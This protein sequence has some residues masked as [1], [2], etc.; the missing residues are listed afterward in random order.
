MFPRA[1][2]RNIEM[3]ITYFWI[4]KLFLLLDKIMLMNCS[5]CK[6]SERNLQIFSKSFLIR[7]YSNAFL[8]FEFTECKNF[9]NFF[10]QCIPYIIE[11]FAKFARK[12]KVYSYD[13]GCLK[14]LIHHTSNGNQHLSNIIYGRSSSTH[15]GFRRDGEVNSHGND[16][17][18]MR[19][20]S[21]S[22]SCN[23][24]KFINFR[25]L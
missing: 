12:K 18:D 1:L 20:S 23:L 7:K 25:D 17:F 5:T 13:K 6:F 2:N 19:F 4:K 11:V 8:M 21:K 24:L 16:L 3:D 22:F 9:S 14:M 10:H 15:L